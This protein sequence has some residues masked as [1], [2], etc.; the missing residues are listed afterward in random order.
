MPSDAR[1][2]VIE[3]C[4]SFFLVVF[5]GFL[6]LLVAAVLVWLL[7]AE[8]LLLFLLPPSALPRLAFRVPRRFSLLRLLPCRFRP[9][10]D[11]IDHVLP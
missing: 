7:L 3:V 10:L 8:R 1:N 11:P 9:Y 4:S 5:L 2:I 6:L